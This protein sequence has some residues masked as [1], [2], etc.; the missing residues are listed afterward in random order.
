MTLEF[1]A[2][3]G[4][5]FIVLTLVKF[6]QSYFYLFLFRLTLK[7]CKLVQRMQCWFSF[8][9]LHINFCFHQR[10]F[11]FSAAVDEIVG[12]L[13]GGGGKSK[14]KKQSNTTS[15]IQIG[16]GAGKKKQKAISI[17]VLRLRFIILFC[18]FSRQRCVDT[19]A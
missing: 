6:I 5:A 1:V 3:P 10:L 18:V 13:S 9:L 17:T 7:T 19:M 11:V 12:E 16:D 2:R 8:L 14:G 4:V 15:T